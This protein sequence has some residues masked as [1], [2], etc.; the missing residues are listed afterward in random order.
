MDLSGFSDDWLA[1]RYGSRAI[2]VERRVVRTLNHAHTR[3]L[4][5]HEAGRLKVNHAYGAVMSRAVNDEIPSAFGDFADRIDILGNGVQSPVIST[6]G[7]VFIRSTPLRNG[8]WPRLSA[9]ASAFR[10][11]IIGESSSSSHQLALSFAP[12]GD[13]DSVGLLEADVRRIIVAY[14]AY[15][16]IGVSTVVIGEGVLREDGT[17]RFSDAQRVSLASDEGSTPLGTTGRSFADAPIPAPA[18]GKSAVEPAR[19]E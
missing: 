14:V 9:K 2:E 13:E 8:M 3:A 5:A 7:L 6:D 18:L 10:Q 15:P 12:A 4:D 1:R 19:I 16:K 11:R 17:L